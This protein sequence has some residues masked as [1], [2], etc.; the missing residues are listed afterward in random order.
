MLATI[1]ILAAAIQTQCDSDVIPGV[2][3]QGGISTHGSAVVAASWDTVRIFKA[4]GG[5]YQEVAALPMPDPSGLFLQRIPVAVANG[6]VVVGREEAFVAGRQ[7]AGAVDLYS[8]SGNDLAFLTTIVAPGPDTAYD[9]FGRA[10][11]VNW[12]GQAAT[13]D[14][15][16][17]AP[18]DGSATSVVHC[19]TMSPG[20]LIL[21]VQEVE[22]GVATGFG[23]SIALTRR[24]DGLRLLLAGERNYGGAG[25]VHVYLKAGSSFLP[26]QTIDAPVGATS[27]GFSLGAGGQRLLALSETHG[28]VFAFKAPLGGQYVFTQELPSLETERARVVALDALGNRAFVGAPGLELDGP[29]A[30]RVT[31]FHVVSGTGNFALSCIH[32]G[33]PQIRLGA[34]L[35][36]DLVRVFSASLDSSGDIWAQPAARSPLQKAL[37]SSGPLR[38]GGTIYR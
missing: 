2:A 5:A 21:H 30:G 25:A 9:R 19:Y 22:G 24:P 33:A 20:G 36:A 10:V 14:I 15:A 6:L 13:Y 3:T 11:A 17:S 34:L 38:S 1:C 29:N 32:H 7:N 37:P 26:F 8:L 16:V 18:R 28:R 31:E 4:V 27:F 35:A 23:E 12:N